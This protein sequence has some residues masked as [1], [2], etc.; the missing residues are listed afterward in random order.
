ML[1]TILDPREMTPGNCKMTPR[2]MDKGSLWL[3]HLKPMGNTGSYHHWCRIFYN[4]WRK[5]GNNYSG[6][7]Q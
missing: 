1:V 2:F 7:R 6:P 5:G 4:R 3:S